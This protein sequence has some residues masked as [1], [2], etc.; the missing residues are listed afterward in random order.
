MVGGGGGEGGGGR[1]G[2]CGGCGRQILN[3]WSASAAGGGRGQ[4]GGATGGCTV[5]CQCRRCCLP[6]FVFVFFVYLAGRRGC[7]TV[8]RARPGPTRAGLGGRRCSV[9]PHAR[10][11]PHRPGYCKI[12]WK[13]RN[14]H[15]HNRTHTHTH[16]KKDDETKQAPKRWTRKVK[17]GIKTRAPPHAVRRRGGVKSAAC[18]QSPGATT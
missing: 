12:E 1:D 6:F 2:R 16:K 9:E 13:E 7:S 18:R 3:V 8:G 14:A 5:P 17:K 15:G 4:A 11:R 10:A